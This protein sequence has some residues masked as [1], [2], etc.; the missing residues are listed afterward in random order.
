MGRGFLVVSSGGHGSGGGGRCKGGAGCC[1]RWSVVAGS[2][3]VFISAS[4]GEG[5]SRHHG[6]PCVGCFSCVSVPVFVPPIGCGREC[7]QG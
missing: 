2:G 6:F 1:L 4:C 3:G 5:E 7:A